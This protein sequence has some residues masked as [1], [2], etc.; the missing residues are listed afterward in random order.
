[1]RRAKT[2]ARTVAPV[3]PAT[4]SALIGREALGDL[5]RLRGIQ[6]IEAVERPIERNIQGKPGD[7]ETKGKRGSAR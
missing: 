3:M 6:T 1:M 4:S 2:V 7:R 5:G